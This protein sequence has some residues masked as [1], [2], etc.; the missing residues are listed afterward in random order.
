MVMSKLGLGKKTLIKELEKI[1][2][3]LEVVERIA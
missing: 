2:E 3:L 1:K